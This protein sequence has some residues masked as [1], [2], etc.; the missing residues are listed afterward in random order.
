MEMPQS[1]PKAELFTEGLKSYPDAK[2]AIRAFENL[3]GEIAKRVMVEHLAELR[4]ATEQ[5]AA[6]QEPNI[7]RLLDPTPS[8]VS[9]GAWVNAPETWGIYWGVKWSSPSALEP[10]VPHVCMAVRVSAGYKKDK[11]FRALR[12]G[13]TNQEV[14]VES[15]SGWPYEVHMSKR[16]P[17][18][19][20]PDQLEEALDV[21]VSAFLELVNKAGGMKAAISG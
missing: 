2:E 7:I 18:E 1:D 12:S 15:V 16:L 19:V 4:Q 6:L 11:L 21:V 17:E 3:M 13:S 10:A 14:Q 8:R 20:T 5:P 9:V